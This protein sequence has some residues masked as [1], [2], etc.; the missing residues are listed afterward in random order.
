MV[1]YFCVLDFEATCN[2]KRPKPSPQEIIE[3]P[4]VLLNIKTG[5]VDDIF[6]YYIRPDLHP[7]LSSFCTELTGITQEMVGNNGI[8]LF[9]C[10][11]LH[12]QWLQKHNLVNHEGQISNAESKRFLYVTCGDWDLKTCLPNQLAHHNMKVPNIFNSWVNV[13]KAYGKFYNRKVSGMT[14]MLTDLRLDLQGRH[15]SGIDDS[16]NIA[17]VCA[18][19]V[20]DGWNPRAT[21][22]R[23]A[24]VNAS[25]AKQ[26]V[27]IKGCASKHPNTRLSN[28]GVDQ[29]LCKTIYLIRHGQSEGQVARKQRRD[30][31]D[32][33]LTDCGLTSL[34]RE[35][36]KEIPNLLDTTAIDLVVSSPLTRA[37]KTA[38]LGFPNHDV[39]ILYE[40]REMGSRIPENR[41]RS[42]KRVTKSLEA[43]IED[44]V[45]RG[46]AI[47]MTS[48][49]PAEWPRETASSNV[50]KSERLQLA[51]EWLYK[52]RSERTIA[53]VC[54]YNVIRAILQD[55]LGRTSI[56]PENA[57]PIKCLL[58]PDGSVV[59]TEE[60]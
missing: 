3:F 43:D 14:S 9:E 56:R 40:L 44:R 45:S 36:A 26:K 25:V 13:K 57:D 7:E 6:H 35:Q 37:L 32:P 21:T 47:D 39:L 11:K 15:H 2:D 29:N 51:F 5:E 31:N 18:R 24:H 4:V 28:V 33:S 27:I 60:N 34:G 30:R 48:L 55:R 12:E 1:E 59:T 8:S 19:M 20:A 10:L 38:I 23:G 50:P 58:S 41:P 42:M 46:V 54:H 53:V 52:E 22:R 16:K 17:R 49:Q